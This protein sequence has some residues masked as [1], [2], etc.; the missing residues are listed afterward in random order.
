VKHSF[1]LFLFLWCFAGSVSA[2]ILNDSTRNVYNPKT[3][4]V[5]KEGD[6]L[7][8]NFTTRPVDTALTNLHR[9]RNWYGDT[10]FYQELGNIGMAAKPL[11]WRFPEQIGVRLGRNAYDRYMYEPAQADY[12][13]TKSPY[14]HLFYVQGQQGEQI[15]EA[16]HARS[17][18]DIASFGLSFQ[19]IAANKQIGKGPTNQE[20]QVDNLGFMFFTHVRNKSGRYHLFTNFT[21]GKHEVIESGGIN[22]PEGT[23]LDS[24]DGYDQRNVY[25]A[26]APIWLNSAASE[27]R[28][29]MAHL[30][31]FLQLAKEYIK[32][33][34]TFDY[35]YQKNIYF[36]NALPAN[37]A[38]QAPFYQTQPFLVDSGHTRDSTRYREVENTLGLTGNHPLFYYNIYAK[39]RDAKMHFA[40]L[41][42]ETDTLLVSRSQQTGSSYGQNFIGGETQFKLRD[43][44]NITVKGEYQ[45]FQ[46]YQATA[47][48][49]VKFL[50]FSQSRLSYSPSLL[51]QQYRSNHFR[52][53]NNFENIVADKTAA[54]L[55]G[56]FWNNTLR[57]EVARVNLQHYVFINQQSQPEQLGEQL[58]FYTAYLHHHLKLRNL[59]FDHELSYNQLDNADQIRLPQWL[60]NSKV[61]YEGHLFK[62]ALFGQ[63]GFEAFAMDDF[64]ADAYNPVL[65]QFYLQNSF[66]VPT[67]PVVDFFI[68]AD[69][70]NFNV[71]LKMAHLNQGFPH[72][73]YFTSPYYSGM[74]R[75]FIFGLKWMFFD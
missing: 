10:T 33:Y 31:H 59:H 40:A 8:G 54:G 7:R 20:G 27:E 71:F 19:R 68:T 32:V 3:T 51:Q 23:K 42:T 25:Y 50:T 14:T 64:K 58:S 1:F 67:Y 48:A 37:G 2:Q 39:R 26:D 34:H 70:K 45:L 41:S 18:R 61:Y 49:R 72:N 63:V 53:D 11:L 29:N 28:R 74:Q 22:Y 55:Q 66:T 12:F 73:G 57:G 43:I 47:A 5:F 52:W 21:V 62:K 15:F 60:V 69:I 24:L 17:F 56:K 13:D 36:D 6:F 44:F 30:T 9:T 4:R 16:K 46:D 35:R 38:A 75:S 65:Q